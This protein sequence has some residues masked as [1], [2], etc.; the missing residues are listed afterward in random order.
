MCASR[1]LVDAAVNEVVAVDFPTSRRVE[2]RSAFVVVRKEATLPLPSKTV[3]VAAPP[4]FKML[5][6]L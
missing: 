5:F 1:E 6:E 2:F 4:A 3:V